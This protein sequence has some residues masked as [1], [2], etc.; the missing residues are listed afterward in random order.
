MWDKLAAVYGQKEF[1][2]RH[3]ANHQMATL[4]LSQSQFCTTVRESSSRFVKTEGNRL[5]I[6][7]A[8]FKDWQITSSLAPVQP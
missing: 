8:T 5:Q 2:A 7:H 6:M 1:S 4:S 3:I